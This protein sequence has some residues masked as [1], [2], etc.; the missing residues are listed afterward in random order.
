MKSQRLRHW[1]GQRDRLITIQRAVATQNDYGEEVQVWFPFVETGAELSNGNLT[2][3]VSYQI[4]ATQVNYFGSGLVVNSVF[5]ASS[6]LALSSVNKVKPVTIGATVWAQRKD[7]RGS[8]RYQA[9]QQVADVA[10]TFVIAYRPS[11][12]PVH[13]IVDDTRIYDIKGVAEIGR[14]KLL[15]ISC[16]A[17]AE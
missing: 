10:A 6:A 7:M 13:R 9:E 16:E 17:R 4:T 11:L 5:I 3:G 12:S 1:A 2:V 15:E 14:K 8:E